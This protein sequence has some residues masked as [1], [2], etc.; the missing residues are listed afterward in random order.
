MPVSVSLLLVNMPDSYK[1]LRVPE[2]QAVLE[3]GV[4]QGGFGEGSQYHDQPA[5]YST[6]SPSAERDSARF[7]RDCASQKAK[8]CQDQVHEGRKASTVTGQRHMPLHLNMLSRTLHLSTGIPKSP[9]SQ[10]V[11]GPG[12]R[13]Q[14]SKPC[15]RPALYSASSPP[16]AQDAAVFNRD[17]VSQKSQLLQDQ[18]SEGGKASL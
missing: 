10:A 15:D 2:G 17:S 1:G 13:E 7:N 4:R 18:V 16:A 5:L 11:S 3:P 6:F 8:L 12:A 9:E 14:E